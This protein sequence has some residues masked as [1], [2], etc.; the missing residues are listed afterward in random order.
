LVPSSGGARKLQDFA[1][2]ILQGGA[3]ILLAASA[4]H[5]R[6]LSIRQVRE[7]RHAVLLRAG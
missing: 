5:Y 6:L 1:N 7:Q 4:F 3:A 2:A